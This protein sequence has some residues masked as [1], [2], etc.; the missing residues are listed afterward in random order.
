MRIKATCKMCGGTY[1]KTNGRSMYCSDACKA[2]ARNKWLDATKEK[3]AEYQK[4]YRGQHPNIQEQF[5]QRHPNYSR[6]RARKIR[7]NVEHAKTCVV[8]GKTFITYRSNKKTCSDE[9]KAAHRKARDKHRI[10]TPISPEDEHRKYIIRT[11]GSEEA[12]RAYLEELEQKKQAQMEQTK[13]RKEQER[14]ERLAANFREGKCVVCGKA[15]TTY[16][17][18]QKTC[19]SECGKKLSYARKQKRIPDEQVIDKDI[20]LE[21]LYRRDSGVCY[22]CGGVCDWN[23]KKGNIVGGLYPSIDHIIPVSRGGLHSWDNVRL[24]H[25]QCNA[26]KSNDIIPNAKKMVAVNAY[27]VKKEPKQ[28]KKRTMQYSEAGVFVAEYESTAEAARKTGFKAK[29]IQNCA[30]GERKLYGGFVWKYA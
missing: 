25:F 30:R 26:K 18:L 15:F 21:A 27:S 10:R 5:D 1:W 23:D 2:K 4:E 19:C 17:P 3:R 11:Y 24:A 12:H 8:C 9:C 22:L 20:T 6:D 13:A 29:Q 14:K 7:G 28:S 16:N